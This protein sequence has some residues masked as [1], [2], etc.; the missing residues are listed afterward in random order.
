MASNVKSKIDIERAYQMWKS[1]DKI[2]NILDEFGC[3][4]SVFNK[5][6]NRA[7]VG[8]DGVKYENWAARYKAETDDEQEKFETDIANLM[9]DGHKL[10]E[11]ARDKYLMKLIKSIDDPKFKVNVA[12]G[13][14]LV[15]AAEKMLTRLA[16][17]ES[18]GAGGVEQVKVLINHK[19]RSD[20]NES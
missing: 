15:E 12:D 4:R 3:S 18:G 2:Q 6:R 8:P 17:A 7:I 5:W 9:D 20:S 11:L 19:F 10:I 13:V 1:G 16:E 14:K